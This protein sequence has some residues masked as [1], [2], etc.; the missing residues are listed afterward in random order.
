MEPNTAVDKVTNSISISLW[1]NIR[2]RRTRSTI[3]N[4]CSGCNKHSH[5]SR[6]KNNSA[7]AAIASSR[8]AGVEIWLAFRRGQSVLCKEPI[9]SREISV[10]QHQPQRHRYKRG[11]RN[12]LHRYKPSSCQSNDLAAPWVDSSRR[13][14]WCNS[15]NAAQIQ[16]YRHITKDLAYHLFHQRQIRIACHQRLLSP[17][18]RSR[19]PLRRI[20]HLLEVVCHLVSCK[21]RPRITRYEIR[22]CP[23][24]R[25]PWLNKLAR[26]DRFRIIIPPYNLQLKIMSKLSTKKPELRSRNRSHLPARRIQMKRAAPLI[27]PRNLKSQKSKLVRK[28]RKLVTIT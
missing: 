10:R 1:F 22:S 24:S 12:W 17:P 9:Q 11:Q 19:K 21:F 20:K 18:S 23:N 25:N 2:R 15:N 16:N 14:K 27:V 3:N 5:S 8:L 13:R 4:S 26:W 28:R 6:F 7:P